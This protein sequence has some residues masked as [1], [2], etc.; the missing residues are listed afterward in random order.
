MEATKTKT[1]ILLTSAQRKK[2]KK[3]SRK[4]P[5]A[6]EAQVAANF[7]DIETY[8]KPLRASIQPLYFN[9]AKEV[10]VGSGSKR[11]IVIFYPLRFMMK[12]HRIHRQIVAELEKKFNGK[13]VI[14]IAQRRIAKKSNSNLKTTQRS[15]TMT[16]VHEAILTDILHP[17]EI[18]GRRWRYRA[19]G[20]KQTKV[21]L[22]ERDKDKVDGKLETFSTIYRKLTARDVSF[23]YMTNP[24]LQQ[25][26]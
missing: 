24:L 7:H 15:R 1:K 23:G 11:A 19:D 8:N 10:Q 12:L 3:S 18:V 25:F 17:H 26:A 4:T 16:A 5:T 21:F 14:F 13:T 9:T 2:L 22:D 6:L 20:S